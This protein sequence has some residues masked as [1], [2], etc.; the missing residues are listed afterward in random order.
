MRAPMRQGPKQFWGPIEPSSVSEASEHDSFRPWLSE[1][2]G[3]QNPLVFRG[4][5]G[6]SMESG[7][8]H[9][10]TWGPSGD[11]KAFRF[12]FSTSGSEIQVCSESPLCSN[13]A[14][15]ILA[16]S[17]YPIFGFSSQFGS[18]CRRA[19][20]FCRKFVHGV[21]MLELGSMLRQG[22]RFGPWTFLLQTPAA[23]RSCSWCSS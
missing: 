14:F 8:Q 9:L 13:R 19:I 15:G 22:V 6:I 10:R 1:I 11:V 18:R 16:V 21:W 12:G 4:M 3:I 23:S 2:R 5:H 17:Y 20:G 7:L